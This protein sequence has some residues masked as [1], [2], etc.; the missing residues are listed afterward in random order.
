MFSL[1]MIEKKVQVTTM[2]TIFWLSDHSLFPGI[3][4]GRIKLFII[5]ALHFALQCSG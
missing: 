5:I 2:Y 1:E 4:V 3:N